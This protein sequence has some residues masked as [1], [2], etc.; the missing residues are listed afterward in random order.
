VALVPVAD[1]IGLPTWLPPVLVALLSVAAV[2]FIPRLR[3][4]RWRYEIREDEIDLRAGLWTIRRTL[5][6]IRRVQHVDTESGLLQTFFD[7]ATVN[8]HTAAGTTEIPA[9][10]RAEAEHVRSR[11]AQLARTRD[12]V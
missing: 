8:F 1:D 12:D 11:V 9:L 7:L 4:R 10:K 5:V 3:W 2:V 6:P